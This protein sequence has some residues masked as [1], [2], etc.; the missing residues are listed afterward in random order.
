MSFIGNKYYYELLLTWI[1]RPL[2]NPKLDLSCLCFIIGKHGIGK[3]HGIENAIKESNYNISKFTGNNY[4]DFIDFISKKTCSDIVSQFNGD[5]LIDKIIFIDEFETL[6]LYD[7]TFLNNLVDLL[8]SKRLPAVKIIISSIPLETKNGM[9]ILNLTTKIE[10]SIPNE[11][12][13]YLFLKEKYGGKNDKLLK[14]A[15]NCENNISIAITLANE[16]A[17]IKKKNIEY[18]YDKTITLNNIYDINNINELRNIID[19]DRILH[20]LRYHEN[21]IK[22]LQQKKGIKSKKHNIYINY[23]QALYEWDTMMNYSKKN[24]IDNDIAL[25]YIVYNM[26]TI[27]TL[28]NKKNIPIMFTEFTKIFNYLSLKKKTMITLYN[29]EIPWYNI[30]NVHKNIYENVLKKFST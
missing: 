25:D 11:T 16:L 18:Q 13:I 6:M 30:G 5:L 7:R 8:E 20:P 22:A 15:E 27:Y 2:N 29:S 21:M 17:K 14:I 26:R 12:D 23:L 19:Q 10:L 28:S 24:N 1:Q 3:T 9:K 4:K